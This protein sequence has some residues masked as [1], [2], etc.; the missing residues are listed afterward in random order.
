MDPSG[1]TF[2]MIAEHRGIEFSGHSV[3]WARNHPDL[4]TALQDFRGTLETKH[5]RAL[6]WIKPVTPKYKES[7]PTAICWDTANHQL[8]KGR[9]VWYALHKA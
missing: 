8:E 9:F 2:V 1:G 4:K 3:V 7:H 5:G 6:S